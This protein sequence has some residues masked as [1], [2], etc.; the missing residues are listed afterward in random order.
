MPAPVIVVHDEPDTCE[1]AVSALCAAGI[2]A[3]GFADPM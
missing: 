2:Q 1:L 3:A